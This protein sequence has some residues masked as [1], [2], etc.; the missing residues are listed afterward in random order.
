MVNIIWFLLLGS[1]IITAAIKGNIEIITIAALDSAKM[2]VKIA[3]DLVGLMALWLGLLKIA[4]DS[5][6]VKMLANVFKPITVFLFPSIP[7][8]HPAMGAIIMN[9][10][11]NILGLGNAATPLGLKAMQEMKKLNNTDE[12]SDAMCTFLGLNTSCITL[13]PATIIGIRASAGSTD[14]TAIVGATIL[15][16]STGMIVAVFVDRFLRKTYK[17]KKR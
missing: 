4:E 5:G 13:I 17:N 8:D 14:P 2:A 3:V 10:S 1:G 12:A 6:L 9:I 11:A 15:T 16:T 7:K